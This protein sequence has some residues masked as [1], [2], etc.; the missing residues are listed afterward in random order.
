M[1]CGV[2]VC[3]RLI[4]RFPL[5]RMQGSVIIQTWSNC[6]TLSGLAATGSFNSLVMMS[7]GVLNDIA[8]EVNVIEQGTVTKQLLV[9]SD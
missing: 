9:L 8:V 5:I 7:A 4:A 6:S 1:T 2:N 3:K